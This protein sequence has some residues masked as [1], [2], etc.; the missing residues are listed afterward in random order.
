[1]EAGAAGAD[2]RDLNLDLDLD[3]AAD[4]PVSFVSRMLLL[5]LRGEAAVSVS[6]L[7]VFLSFLSRSLLGLTLLLGILARDL[8]TT[9]A[10]VLTSADLGADLAWPRPRVSCVLRLGTRAWVT[11]TSV[12]VTS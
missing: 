7:R 1:M 5:S 4:L 11:L 2:T 3:F 9:G 12:V 8:V 10:S 6:T